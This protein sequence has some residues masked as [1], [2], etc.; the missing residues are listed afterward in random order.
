M[1]LETRQWS[2][3]A[4]FD[5]CHDCKNCW[6]GCCCPCVAY[7]CIGQN[8]LG[9]NSCGCVADCLLYAFVCFIPGIP[10]LLGMTRREYLRAKY[11]LPM[12]PCGDCCVHCCCHWCA[13]CQ[14][15]RESEAI[16]ERL[17]SQV[18][19]HVA[20]SPSFQPLGLSS[21]DP[22]GQGTS[23]YDRPAGPPIVSKASANMFA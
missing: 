16:Q 3:G 23:Y 6:L 21:Y 20:P 13:L 12:K 18:I 5:C 15:K 8:V 22:Y 14:E 1:S 9:Q 4:L 17:N 7:A 19:G 2:T 11:G 10:C